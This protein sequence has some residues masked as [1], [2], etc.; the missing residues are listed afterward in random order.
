M[1]ATLVKSSIAE[2][3]KSVS[4]SI[5]LQNC[6]WGLHD[7]VNSCH[8]DGAHAGGAEEGVTFAEMTPH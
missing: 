2:Q 4:Y 8:E 1:L 7:A 5:E 6:H 3:G